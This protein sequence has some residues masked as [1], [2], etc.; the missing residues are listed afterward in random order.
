[1]HAALKNIVGEHVNQELVLQLIV[2]DCALIFAFFKNSCHRNKLRKI[3]Q[4]VN[5]AILKAI[6]VDIS[7]KTQNEAK[8]MGAMAL[9]GE[10]YMAIL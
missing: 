4:Q 7:E 10:K 6:T 1:M 2:N 5:E 3:E 9:F 8:E